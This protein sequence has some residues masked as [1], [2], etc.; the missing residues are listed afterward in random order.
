MANHYS[1]DRAIGLLMQHCI[2]NIYKLLEGHITTE[3]PNIKNILIHAKLIPWC[4][5]SF[6]FFQTKAVRLYKYVCIS[7]FR[8]FLRIVGKECKVGYV[9]KT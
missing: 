2:I 7:I 3:N 9:H 1:C 4:F 6:V 8:H 5:F